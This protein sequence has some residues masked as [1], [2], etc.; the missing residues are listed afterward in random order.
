MQPNTQSLETQPLVTVTICTRNRAQSLARTLNFVIAAAKLVSE[1][2]ELLVV[3]N[4]STD[5]TQE[6]IAGF[7][8]DLPIR[9]VIQQV[10]GL[11]NA[12]NAGVAAAR[13]RYMM[14]TDDDVMLD[15]DWL[16]AYIEAFRQYPE[17]GI[18]GGRGLP[19]YE[20]PKAQW[21]AAN[22]KHL[23]FLLGI[24]NSPDW[25][26]ITAERLPY[27]INYAV[28]TDI[29]RKYLYDVNLGIAPGRR[30][31]GEETGMISAALADGVEGRWVWGSTVY[32]LIPPERQTLECIRHYYR[33]L[34]YAHPKVDLATAPL[35]RTKSFAQVSARLVR[36]G[37]MAWSRK[38]VGHENWMASYTEY[39]RTLGAWDRLRGRQPR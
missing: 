6:I 19:R 14:W 1:P 32:H 35:V 37:I 29:Q 16:Q 2:W 15:P 36:K 25:T 8:N 12:R 3:D 13:G 31:G 7:A 28:R 39:A 38:L 34:G 33:S 4:G 27:G 21:F 17:M 23:E 5:N 22:E 24:R 18:F 11:S 9:S 26:A 10:P 20:E 30:L